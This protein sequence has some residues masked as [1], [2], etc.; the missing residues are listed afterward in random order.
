MLSFSAWNFG[1]VWA[2]ILNRS[3]VKIQKL[4]QA[5]IFQVVGKAENANQQNE[6]NEAE[7]Q[8][9]AELRDRNKVLR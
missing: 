2:D 3:S 4:C 6:E 8:R 5:V 9:E 1:L 7:M